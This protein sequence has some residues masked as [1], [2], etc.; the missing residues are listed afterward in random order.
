MKQIID[1]LEQLDLSEFE[2]KLY[3]TLLQN[4]HLSIRELAK[5]AG[6]KRTTAYLHIDHLI[7][8]GL[9]TE[10]IKGSRKYLA[11]QD[12]EENLKYLIEKKIQ[13]AKTVQQEFTQ[14][15]QTIKESLPQVKP[16]TDAEIIY[17]KGKNAVKKIYEGAFNGKE[18]RSYVKVEETPELS[19]DNVVL[20]KNAFNKNKKLKMWEIIYE[21][22]RA[23]KKAQEIHLQSD[24]YFYKFM[25]G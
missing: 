4:G 14:I 13:T 18:I 8:K 6:I 25:P 24:R 16:S 1:Y 23:Q 2:A 20:F 17:F 22:P 5:K 11:A 15:V 19:P 3:L 10:L 21:S 9:V 7:E 12:L